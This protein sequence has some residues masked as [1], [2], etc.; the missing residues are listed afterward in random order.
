LIA[1]GGG[2]YPPLCLGILD[3]GIFAVMFGLFL[4]EF[5]VTVPFEEAAT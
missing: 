2:V 4:W 1:A 5:F 3:G